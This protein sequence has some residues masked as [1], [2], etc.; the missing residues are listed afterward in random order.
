[1]RHL[2]FF[3][4]ALALSSAMTVAARAPKTS[5]VAAAVAASDRNPDN[6]KLDESRKPAEVLKFLGL[7]PGMHVL[8]LL[9]AN[10]YWAEIMVPVI[11][12]KGQMLH[13]DQRV[14]R[15]LREP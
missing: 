9:G 3:A 11:G 13:R 4:A 2:K 12:P 7:T 6:V 14:I 15:L 5:A 1:M 8:D 10:A